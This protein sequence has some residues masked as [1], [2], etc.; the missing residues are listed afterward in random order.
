MLSCGI[1]V[2]L[3]DNLSV[4]SSEYLK[5]YMLFSHLDFFDSKKYYVYVFKNYG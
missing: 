1:A 4:I 3:P 5:K 2:I